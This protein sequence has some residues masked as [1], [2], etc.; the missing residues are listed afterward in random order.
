MTCTT[1][2][3]VLYFILNVMESEMYVK[4]AA[5]VVLGISLAASGAVAA[6][7]KPQS[8]VNTAQTAEPKRGVGLYAFLM[9]KRSRSLGKKPQKIGTSIE[10]PSRHRK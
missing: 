7:T 6:G 10:L 2:Q 1:G 9:K 8:S 3:R 4:F 5:A